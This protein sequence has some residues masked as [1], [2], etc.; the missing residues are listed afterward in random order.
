M[1]ETR[2]KQ[3][4]ITKIPKKFSG[5]ILYWMSRDQRVQDNFALAF[6]QK[7]A[8]ENSQP[9]LVVFN[10]LEEFP[11][12]N[13]RN[14][15]FMFE[16]LE[17]IEES[18]KQLGISFI[19]TKGKPAKTIQYII[20]EYQIS[21][22][23]ADFSPLKIAKSLLQ[24]VSRVID[25]PIII[26]DTHN[27]VPCWIAS[28]KQEFSARTI[29]PKLNKLLDEY[30]TALPQIKKHQYQS[31]NSI[32]PI[33][34]EKM[35]EGL[36]LDASVK[37]VTWI[38]SGETEA[39]LI[40]S[41]FI[42]KRLPLYKEQK[43][44]PTKTA[45]SLLSPYL[46]FGQLSAQRVAWEVIHANT[47]PKNAKDVFLEELII[48]KEL[49]D[50]Y[51]YYNEHYDTFAG[52]HSWA[53]TTLAKHLI[54]KREYNYSLEEF[55]EAKTHDSLWNAAQ[56]EMVLT[57][58]MHGYLRMYWAKKILE[59]TET[60]QE[61][62]KIAIKLNDKYEL[63]GRDSN[64]YTGIAW[65]IGGIHDRPWGPERPIF[66]LVR[67]MNYNGAKRKFKVQT[68]IEKMQKLASTN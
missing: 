31:N 26:V 15:H 8:L 25:I 21:L 16:N 65:S 37:K 24:E 45:L 43:N 27:I 33:N 46:H 34:W 39:H 18:L 28:L 55:E 64:G 17:L 23:V 6:A 66:G 60:P 38:K 14:A 42:E 50:N 48:R 44:D 53:Q 9:L 61:A 10:I 13:Q 20:Q 59:W 35:L 40:L 11:N 7:K 4:N 62:Q 5:S 12:F 67:Y 49:A 68:Y 1:I 3:I 22:L 29:R 2:T 30:F 19:V 47:V 36:E 32:D 51:C 56:Q 58:K 57:G 52:F 54:D 63:D 41:N